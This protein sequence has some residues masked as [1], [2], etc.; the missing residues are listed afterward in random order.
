MI[1][2][3]IF[4]FRIDILQWILNQ[5]RKNFDNLYILKEIVQNEIDNLNINFNESII[6]VDINNLS[7]SIEILQTCL[8]LIVTELEM[9]SMENRNNNNNNNN[10]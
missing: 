2:I 7:K 4:T 10:K 1:P 5:K 8:F 9:Y 6:K 3:K